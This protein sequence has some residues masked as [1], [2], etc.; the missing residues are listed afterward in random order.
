MLTAL[1]R[2]VSPRLAHCELEFLDRVPID[3]PAA[4]RQHRAYEACLESL[5]TRVISLPPDPALPDSVFVEDTAIVLDEIAIICRSGVESRRKEID[6][7][8]PALA[9]FR[10]LKY[11]HYPGTVEGGDIMRIGNTLYVGIS[12]R[13]NPEGLRQL[14]EH[15]RVV[16]IPVLGSLH[17]KARAA[18]WT[19]APSSPIATG[20]SPLRS[21]HST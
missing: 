21:I 19:T 8:A 13:T 1:T 16:P 9:P 15:V 2:A 6:S 3:V 14:A 17:F 5:G 11:I 10:D 12:R 7:I 20:S 18:L 4:A